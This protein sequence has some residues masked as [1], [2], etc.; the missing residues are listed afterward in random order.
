M[1]VVILF[2]YPISPIYRV[3]KQALTFFAVKAWRLAPT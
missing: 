1:D 3:K 2:D